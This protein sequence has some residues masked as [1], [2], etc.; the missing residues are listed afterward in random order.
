MLQ[1][2]VR[3]LMFESVCLKSTNSCRSK[4]PTQLSVWDINIDKSLIARSYKEC[5]RLV[6]DAN[7]EHR[8][9]GLKRFGPKGSLIEIE[10]LA[11]LARIVIS[12]FRKNLVL[13]TVLKV[14]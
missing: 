13:E 7:E 8:T 6:N 4:W 12:N 14:C 1:L 5:L 9:T 3:V 10:S 2:L 11:N